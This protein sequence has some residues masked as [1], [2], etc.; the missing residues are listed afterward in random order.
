M[1]AGGFGVEAIWVLEDMNRLRPDTEKWNI[2]GYVDD[3]TFKKDS[4][5]YDYST[6]GSPEKI[7]EAYKGK[8]LWYYCAIGN[9][10]VRAAVVERL[11]K[12]GWHAGILV[13]PSA[14]FARNIA[15]GEG[16]YIGPGA[17]VCPNAVIGKHVLINTRAVIGHDA[18][19][20]DFSQLCPGAQI[21]GACRVARGALIGSN[22]SLLPGASVGEWA[23]V[24]GNSQ[25]IRSV[26][27]GATVYGVPAATLK[28]A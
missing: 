5:Y 23:T 20:E 15:I 25:V 21:N 10:D 26:K 19:I 18:I 1:G 13:H 14:I 22:A 6:L 11:D 4:M 27:A 17:I 12:L 24:G 9:N 8:D 16:T 2:L 28:S 3:D 7:A